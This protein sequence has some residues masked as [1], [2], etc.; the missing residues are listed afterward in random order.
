MFGLDLGRV[1]R[2]HQ[3]SFLFWCVLYCFWFVLAAAGVRAGVFKL[4]WEYFFVLG[5]LGN[6]FLVF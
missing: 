1:L 6:C 2:V 3:T 4:A 5:Y